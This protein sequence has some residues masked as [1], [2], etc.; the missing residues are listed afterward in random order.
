MDYVGCGEVRT[1]SIAKI[2]EVANDT[3]HFVHHILRVHCYRV[4]LVGMFIK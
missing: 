3:V 1:A 2:W 4:K